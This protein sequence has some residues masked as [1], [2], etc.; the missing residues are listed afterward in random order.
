MEAFHIVLQ[1]THI[2]FQ[3]TTLVPSLAP[4]LGATIMVLI[5]LW[6]SKAHVLVRN[7]GQLRIGE[8]SGEKNELVSGLGTGNGFSCTTFSG[9][10]MLC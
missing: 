2:M 3:V 9:N 7:H 5:K 6:D 4:F 10:I 8:S 1:A